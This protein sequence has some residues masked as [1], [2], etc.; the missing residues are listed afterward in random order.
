MNAISLKLQR[1]KKEHIESVWFV[2]MSKRPQKGQ[3]Q[4]ISSGAHCST[5]D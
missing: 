1:G 5:Q 2:S 3:S 4:E